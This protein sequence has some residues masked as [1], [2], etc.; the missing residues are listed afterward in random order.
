M[1]ELDLG[2]S[3]ALALALEIRAD[4]I[5]IDEAAGRAM[6]KRMGVPFIGVFGVLLE[7]KRSGL[8]GAVLPLLDRLQNDHGFYLSAPVR[9][10]VLRLAGES[11]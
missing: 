9:D 2:E 3:E 5:L 11:S 6:A 1:Q 4:L 8:I 10:E 7:A